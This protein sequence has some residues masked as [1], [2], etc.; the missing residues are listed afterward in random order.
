MAGEHTLT[1]PKLNVSMMMHT[2]NPLMSLPSIN[3][4]KFTFSNI[5]P[6]QDFRGQGHY[7]KVKS[8]SH[9]HVAHLQP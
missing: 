1:D 9:H 8:R 7:G 5:L 2:Y 4:L 6:G 3:S